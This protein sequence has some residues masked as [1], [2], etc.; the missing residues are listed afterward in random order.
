MKTIT[1]LFGALV[2]TVAFSGNA[3]A[4]S[5]VER[6]KLWVSNAM[7]GATQN[8]RGASREIEFVPVNGLAT[9]LSATGSGGNKKLYILFKE[10]DSD[11]E[12]GEAEQAILFGYDA[13]SRWRS[14]NTGRAPSKFEWQRN[15]MAACLDYE[16]A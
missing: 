10:S 8:M 4:M 2:S 5:D 15:L 11:G 12:R 16:E 9:F 13:M 14:Q 6:C 7:Y 3:F 1:L